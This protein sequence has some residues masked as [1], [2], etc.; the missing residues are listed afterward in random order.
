MEN[1]PPKP[2]VKRGK[3]E[4]I[5]YGWWIVLACSVMTSYSA[6]ILYYG[7]TAFFTPL[8][9]EFGWSRAATSLAFSLYRLEGGL[10]APVVGFF[11]DRLGPRKMMTAA[12]VMLGLGFILLSRINSLGGFY[13]VFLFIAFSNSLG[14]LPVGNFAVSNWFVKKRGIALGLL[15]G[16]ISLCGLLVPVLTWMIITWGW[17][18]AAVIAGI[19]MWII[20]VPLAMV[21]RN[22]PEPYG[23]LPDG[24]APD[25]NPKVHA[26]TALVPS[27]TR[28]EREFT[29]GQAVHTRSFWLF[30]TSLIIPYMCNAALFVHEI[31]FLLQAGIPMET[32]ALVVTGTVLLS[33]VG[34]VGFGC[35]SDRF[36]K[37][38][39]MAIAMASQCSGVLVFA[40]IHA[41]WQ[42]VPFMVLFGVGYGGMNPL[43]AAIQGEYFGTVA[44]GS[45]QGI[46]LGIWSVG[47][48]LGP[49]LAGRFFDVTSDYRR[50][51]M[52]LGVAAMS[53]ALPLMLACK[54]PAPKDRV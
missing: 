10:A 53:S 26:D 45:I 3:V 24:K 16:G 40:N 27:P 19:G 23:L 44:F 17:R 35:L 12:V 14:F 52:M 33:G 46:L 48:M 34:R 43:R 31:P 18:T 11:I 51:F 39:L 6:G 30:S 7:F 29:I 50:V 4:S 42:V 28:G 32:A 15:S 47:T 36:S 13:A 54:P 1:H 21:I 22:R 5:F 20:G 49:V 2:R 37:R 8:I 41:L 9:Q 25:K 38:Y